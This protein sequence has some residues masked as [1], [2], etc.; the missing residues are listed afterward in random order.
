MKLRKKLIS[1]FGFKDQFSGV[2]QQISNSKFMEKLRNSI[3]SK[4][5]IL[6]EK[7]K[8]RP[9]LYLLP[10]FALVAGCF[11]VCVVSIFV[12]IG[13]TDNTK[14]ELE[15]FEVVSSGFN[16]L[17]NIEM[18]QSQIRGAENMKNE[19]LIKLV[20]ETDSLMRLTK[21]TPSDTVTILRNYELL[22]RFTE[23]PKGKDKSVNASELIHSK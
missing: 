1:C 20:N 9:K 21:K 11:V 16:S 3:Q 15:D 14:S 8:L 7:A 4:L 19:K 23:K 13:R 2:F 6:N 12:P 22:K 5:F 18:A 10:L 17:Y